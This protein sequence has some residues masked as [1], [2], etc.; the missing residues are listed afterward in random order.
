MCGPLLAVACAIGLSQF[1]TPALAGTL[2]DT[3]IQPELGAYSQYDL[4]FL[5]DDVFDVATQEALKFTIANGGIASEITIGAGNLRQYGAFIDIFRDTNGTLVSTLANR[6]VLLTENATSDVAI[7]DPAYADCCWFGL[8]QNYM[9]TYSGLS[10]AFAP[11]DYW[12]RITTI[13]PEFYYPPYLIA[14]AGA[15]TLASRSF[16]GMGWGHG[17]DDVTYS[18]RPG[19]L[20]SIRI[21][22]TLDSVVPEP[23]SWVM[24]IAG[25]GLAGVA[26]RRRSAAQVTG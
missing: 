14:G 21:I 8:G 9:S 6:V 26:A 17:Y 12:I 1:A 15:G 5:G 18:Y 19:F 22:G 3:G 11:G 13:A 25:F 4:D 24:M 7:D 23:A 16:Y 2:L 20:P 10:L